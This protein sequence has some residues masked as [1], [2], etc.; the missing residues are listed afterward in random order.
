MNKESIVT[1]LLRWVI[2]LG[3]LSFMA[4]SYWSS[5]LMEKEL[6]AVRKNVNLL[7]ES[8]QALH[9]EIKQKTVSN[10]SNN[11]TVEEKKK[12][13]PAIS[14]YVNT[15]FPNLLIEDPFYIHTLPELL[16][17]SFRPHGI[18]HTASLG[19]PKNLHPFSGWAD[20]SNWQSLCVASAATQQFGKYESL[21][22]D[23]AVKI[24]ERT[25]E[26]TQVPEFWVFLRNDLFWDPLSPDQ[27]SEEIHLSPHFL[28]KH[29]VNAYDFK[30]YYDAIMNPFVQESGAV[31]LRNYIG[32]I[33][34]IRIV[35]D[36]TFVVRWKTEKI[37]R[38]DGI[39]IP[40]IKYIAKFWTG[41]LK[42]LPSFVYQYFADGTKIIEDDSDPDTYRKNSVWAQN[43]S[44][45]WARNIIP[46]SGPWSFEK[47]TERQINFRRKPDYFSPL[48]ALTEAQEFEFKESP[49]SIW[50]D[51]KLGKLDLYNL[52][53]QQLVEWETFSRSSEYAKQQA[54]NLAIKRLDYLARTYTYIG[55][56]AAKPYFSSK[57]VR[58]AMTM[59]IDRKR[60]IDNI[61][62][63]MG[64]ELTGPFFIKGTSYDSSI[65]PWPYDPHQARRLLEEEGWFDNEGDGVIKKMIDGQLVPFQ[66][67]ITYYVKSPT[68]AAICDY[69]ATAFKELGILCSLKGVD[70]SD[71]SSIFEDKNFDALLMAW[72]QAT[73]PEE[74]KQ[75]WYSTGAKEKGSSNAVGFANL[76]ADKIIDALQYEYNREKR[77]E[78]YHRLHAIIHEE[79]PYTFLYVPKTTLL[80]R[81][82]LQNV[83]IPADRQ[84]L[85][86][87][88]NVEEPQGNIFWIKE[89]K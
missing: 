37:R 2:Y 26:E 49:Q 65:S 81:E 55:W 8:V 24:E 15:S 35:D 7:Q 12:K 22:P 74:P 88:G 31:A 29:P 68:A 53:P 79:Q 33:E 73:P 32:D 38:E 57:K 14:S 3:I 48:G 4:M 16:G 11:F 19:Q 69:V 40:T 41:A 9:S 77:K 10:D 62:N 6:K 43:F 87:G 82:Y 59:A 78:L 56:N 51:F 44:Q 17:P 23:I 46:S 64:V 42:P 86:P 1:T 30:F 18:R 70:S 28:K 75:L 66:F 50:Q 89:K 34:E 71:I 85:I 61:L 27:F 52:Q 84:D 21:A 76:E 67:S 54:N 5:E 25:I 39:E 20:V 58:Q 72:S 60:I 13:T 83:F 47:M 45:H 80:Y 63:G 36:F